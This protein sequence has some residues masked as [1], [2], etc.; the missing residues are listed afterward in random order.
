[1][2]SRLFM[3][4]HRF[5]LA[6]VGFRSPSFVIRYDKVVV[7]DGL[8][9]YALPFLLAFSIHFHCTWGSSSWKTAL[10][11]RAPLTQAAGPVGEQKPNS[12]RSS[13]EAQEQLDAYEV[14]ERLLSNRKIN[15]SNKQENPSF[16]R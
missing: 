1:M 12:N 7:L 10:A 14:V 15:Y 11:S 6:W 9:I 13:F 3:F 2:A 8:S 5:S 16:Q 4:F